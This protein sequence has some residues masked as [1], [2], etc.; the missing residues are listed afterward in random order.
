MARPAVR[1]SEKATRALKMSGA[2]FPKAKKVTPWGSTSRGFHEDYS[3]HL[4][5]LP[6][7]TTLSHGSWVKGYCHV[8]G[9]LEIG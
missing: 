9:E 7:S 2:P 6:P 5:P 8:V 3:C 1:G 4:V